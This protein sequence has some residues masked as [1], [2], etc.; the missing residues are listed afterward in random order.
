MKK[1][2]QTKTNA[3][4]KESVG[5]SREVNS[6]FLGGGSRR[7]GSRTSCSFSPFVL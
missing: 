3:L 4:E 6:D 1:K 2:L 5:T 7:V